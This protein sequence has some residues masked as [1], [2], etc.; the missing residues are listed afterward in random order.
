MAKH[1]VNQ[2]NISAS[3]MRS[4]PL[5]M[6]STDLQEDFAQHIQDVEQ[7]RQVQ[8]SHLQ[9]LGELFA[10]LQARAFSGRL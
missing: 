9:E 8:I 2:A 7:Q 3:E 1:A 5:A 10:S 4:I 6:P